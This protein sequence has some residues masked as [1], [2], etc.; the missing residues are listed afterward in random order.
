M[1]I[2]CT[3]ETH[4]HF[5]L[6]SIAYNIILIFKKKSF[7]GERKFAH[8][9]KGSKEDKGKIKQATALSLTRKRTISSEGEA[10]ENKRQGCISRC[11][12]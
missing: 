6:L 1:N 4:L 5:F 9:E 8:R 7:I 11:S 12:M 3:S 2:N 10:K